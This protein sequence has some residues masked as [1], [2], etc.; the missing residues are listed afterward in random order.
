ME[1]RAG[2]SVA[3]IGGGITGLSAAL[4][5]RSLMPA[6]E[7]HLFESGPR[8]GGVLQT[9]R[10]DDYLV[11]RS[12]D[13]FTVREPWALE[14]CR[15][16]GFEE[17]LITT[18]DEFRKAFVV[19][20]GKLHKVPD[21]LS[22]LS[23]TKAMPLLLSPLLSVR[24]KLRMMY[25]PLVR[26]RMDESDESLAS[27]TR[28]RLGN[29]AYEQLIQPLIGGIYTADPEKLSMQ[30]TL[31]QF[32]EMERNHGGLIR[33]A[34]KKK[35]KADKQASGAR[36]SLF[37]AP[38]E[39]MSAL[40]DAIQSKLDR[41]NIALETTIDSL[42]ANENASETKQWTLHLDN[43]DSRS[44][45]GV[46]VAANASLAGNMLAN[47]D[48]ELA[49]NLRGIPMAGASVVTCGFKRSQVQHPADAFGIVVPYAEGR[50]LIAISFASVKFSGRAPDD[51]LLLR[52]FVGG[53][54]QPEL[55]E[56]SDEATTDIV[57]S[58]LRELLG[59]SGDPDFCR[60]VRWTGK[61]PQYHIGHLDRVAKIEQA[62]ASLPQ[63]E[64]AGN[65]YRGVGIP[66]CVRSGEQA[67]KR[68][69]ADLADLPCVSHE[70]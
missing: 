50:K 24:G 15:K 21:G 66:F 42:Q 7:I 43:G 54:L 62:T 49:A 45:D 5:L 57:L 52:I 40:I 35:S 31:P 59:T 22:L 33:G 51:R 29:E 10:I 44:F 58:E 9:E 56:L 37:R 32:P 34:R 19:R 11:E 69:H 27:F 12:A 64:I 36:Y 38:R 2:H 46:I 18:N 39:G 20:R 4:E 60:V 41:V 17:Q 6:A 16:I 65:A 1:E 61:M 25:E 23:P 8:L 70:L 28:R 67:A 3:I 47:V 55:L 48:G 13:M 68:L 30:A 53:A 26:P 63:L 14:L